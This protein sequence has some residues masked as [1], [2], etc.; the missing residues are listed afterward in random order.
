[1]FPRVG[2]G[3]TVTGI[4]QTGLFLVYFFFCER[5]AVSVR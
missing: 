1:M 3:F 2:W 4:L 5:K